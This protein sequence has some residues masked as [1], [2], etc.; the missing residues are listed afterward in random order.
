[1]TAKAKAFLGQAI[2]NVGPNVSKKEAS[3][4]ASSTGKSV[5]QVMAKAQEKGVALSSSL[6]NSFNRGSMGPNL[7]GMTSAFGVALARPGINKGTARALES[8]T[9]LQ[10]LQM[11]KGTVYAGYSTTTP[12]TSVNTPY[13]GHSSTPKGTTY[14]PIILPKSL[15]KSTEIQKGSVSG[16]NTSSTPAATNTVSATSA[17]P[18]SYTQTYGSGA[19]SMFA[20]DNILKQDAQAIA[21]A[22]QRLTPGT[23]AE[24]N[25]A[26]ADLQKRYTSSG[27]IQYAPLDQILKSYSKYGNNPNVIGMADVTQLKNKGYKDADIR[28][29]GL[30]SGRVGSQARQYLGI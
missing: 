19:D 14:N 18:E 15:F 5:A 4:I 10:N 22:T 28:Q 29:F 27:N 21:A 7:T 13:G 12:R 25:Q 2:R 26:Y 11:N 30:A 8:L 17:A 24:R 16:S 3:R 9:P 6:V 23:E 1:M 20:R